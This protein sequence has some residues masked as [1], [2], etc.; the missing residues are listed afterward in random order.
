MKNFF[1]TLTLIAV[2]ICGNHSTNAQSF[3]TLVYHSTF[4]IPFN[5]TYKNEPIEELSGIEYT[6]NN[7]QYYVIPQ[8]KNKSYVFLCSI[9]VLDDSIHVKIDSLLYF[10]HGS[11]EAESIRINPKNKQIYIAEEGDGYSHIY[12]LNND[13]KLD[14]IYSSPLPQK[15]NSGYEGLCFNTTG[16]K[17]YISLERPKTGNTSRIIVC[18]LE[19]NNEVIYDYFLD[20]LP[21]DR[22]NDNGISEL[23]YIDDSTLLVIERAYLGE[24]HGMS[25]RAYKVRIPSNGEAIMK[26]KLLTNFSDIPAI[27][28]IEGVTYSA[29]GK[30]LIFIS[31]NNANQHQQTLFICMK[32]E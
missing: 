27:D 20:E 16:T 24:K 4:T 14:A 28:N 30:E 22:N 25:V 31:D 15:T 26:I 19:N 11:L 6:G 23:L 13:N 18:D 8:S 10:D 9:Y 21:L 29:S 17:M 12:R 7:N 5:T 2:I 32:I 3:D 1:L